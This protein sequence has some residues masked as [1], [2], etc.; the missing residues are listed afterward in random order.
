MLHDVL[1]ASTN[2]FAAY[3]LYY[4]EKSRMIEAVH[5]LLFQSLSKLISLLSISCHCNI[6]VMTL[7]HDMLDAGKHWFAIYYPYYKNKFVGNLTWVFISI[8][9]YLYFLYSWSNLLVAFFFAYNSGAYTAELGLVTKKWE[10]PRIFLY[11]FSHLL[12]LSSLFFSL[13]PSQMCLAI[14]KCLAMSKYV[15]IF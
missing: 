5:D 9:N 14:S 6:K 11:L 8:T 13:K 2:C 3:H 4:K 12:L 1:E 10:L 15:I 7:L